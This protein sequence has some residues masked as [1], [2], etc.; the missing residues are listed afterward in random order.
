MKLLFVIDSLE[1][2][3]AARVT[4]I[5]ANEFIKNGYD[6]AIATNLAYRSVI[7]DVD[8]QVKLVSFYTK[9][10]QKKSKFA[11]L[12]RH[13]Y[14]L[15]RIIKT[16][17]PDVIIGEQEGGVLYSYIAKMCLKIP[18]IGHRHNTFKILGLSK[19]NQLIYYLPNKTVLLHKEDV[20]YVGARIKNTIAIYNPHT[21]PVLVNY[22]ANR[23]NQIVCVGSIDRWYNKGF[24]SIL[25]IWSDIENSHKDWD[26]LIVGGGKA[27]S[28]NRLKKYA[29][30]Y[31]CWNRVIFKGAMENIDHLLQE[32]SIFA[33][34]SRVEG[35][36]MVLNEAISQGCPSIAFSL[37]GVLK[38][39]YS[40]ES[41]CQIPDG[42]TELFEKKLVELM[43]NENIRNR[44]S[45]NAS[46]ETIKYL[47]ENIVK[48]WINI[49]SEVVN[50]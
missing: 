6:V 29:L 15:R 40:E 49:I 50:K 2:G 39:I 20:K 19:I 33:L 24:D 21:F 48:D 42:D 9:A 45:E 47:P 3:G 7:Y 38:E 34:P 25:K 28:F 44:Y 30:E 32:S 4:S 1:G 14:Y 46:K 12:I 27:S 43:E 18:M 22:S 37:N 13:S 23:K 5:L 26:L 11:K 36:P 16:I 8:P 35:F 17:R 41:V 10:D 31:G